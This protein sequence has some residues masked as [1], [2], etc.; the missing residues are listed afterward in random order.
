MSKRV[1]DTCR[2]S[3]LRLSRK[4]ERK[5]RGYLVPVFLGGLSG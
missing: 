1:D 4:A 3:R 2:D 5:R